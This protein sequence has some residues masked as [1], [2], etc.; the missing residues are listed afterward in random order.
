MCVCFFSKIKSTGTKK[1]TYVRTQ[2][3]QI[4][5]G[6]IMIYQYKNKSDQYQ[7]DQIFLCEIIFFQNICTYVRKQKSKDKNYPNRRM[8]GNCIFS[9]QSSNIYRPMKIISKHNFYNLQSIRPIT[10]VF[11]SA[12]PSPRRTDNYGFKN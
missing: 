5:I 11:V 10:L 1:N 7:Y 8:I 4:K 12:P 2:I 3:E 6:L 9:Y